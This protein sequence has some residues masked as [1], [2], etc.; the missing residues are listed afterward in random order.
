MPLTPI[1]LLLSIVAAPAPQAAAQTQTDRD[2]QRAFQTAS[3]QALDNKPADAVA[4]MEA[5][6]SRHRDHGE[7][8]F[9][10][11]RLYT[12]LAGYD[13]NRTPAQKR[14]LENSARLYIRAVDL[15]T[16]VD[17]KFVSLWK[18]TDI[19]GEEGLN[20][21]REVEKYAKR[22]V[23]DHANRAESHVV[24]AQLLR[25]RGDIAGAADALRAGRSK[26]SEMPSA[27]LLLFNQ[28]LLEQVQNDGTLP[29][30]TTRR[31]LE[32]ANSVADSIITGPKP[33]SR[34]YRLATLAKAM[35]L[36]QM[37]KLVET[38]R[39]RRIQL[40]A[41]SERY[42]API[43][44]HLNGKPPA[45]TRLTAA[46]ADALEWQYIDRWNSRLVD[47]GKFPEAI[48]AYQQYLATQPTSHLAQA[49]LGDVYVRWG[50]QATDTATKTARWNQALV[51][52]Q[53]VIGLAP[54]QAERE[55][56]F[57]DVIDVLRPARLNQ[58][59]QI[60]A[61]SRTMIQRYPMDAAPRGTLALAQLDAG[62]TA[63]ANETIRAART[64]L[65][66]P[67]SRALLAHYLLDGFRPDIGLSASAGP[68]LMDA[69][70]QLITETERTARNDPDV[71]EARVHWLNVKANRFEPDPAKAKALQ[72]QALQLM[73]RAAALR[74]AR[75]IR[76]P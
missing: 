71:M 51:P 63:E 43:E 44:K 36:E 14:A 68:A 55:K 30:E 48:A 72:T 24:Y 32:E 62:R 11:A 60:E 47:D 29:R 73:T 26:A 10:T 61:A 31:L 8:T 25:A 64:G 42:G 70:D 76:E 34:D 56:A 4:T 46:Q 59:S 41:E 7:A 17:G 23:A 69:A 52:L 37:A 67:A 45:P 16:N 50:L 18:L 3:Q 49:R 5:F 74:K 57:L 66:K 13:P 39:Q 53:K 1:V 33:D 12:D 28:Y 2:F 21:P 9:F 6:L 40:L 22:M 54:T 38:D 20:Q 27:A 58:P 15:L 75:A 35:G 65:T 19:Y